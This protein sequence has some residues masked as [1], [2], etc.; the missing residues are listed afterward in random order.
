M[1][2]ETDEPYNRREHVKISVGKVNSYSAKWVAEVSF[3]RFCAF[4]PFFFAFVSVLVSV[5][6]PLPNAFKTAQLCT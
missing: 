3:K 1:E 4:R 6:F 2:K 5:T